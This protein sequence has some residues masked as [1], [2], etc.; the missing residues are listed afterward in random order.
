MKKL[1]IA[2]TFLTPAVFLAFSASP[3]EAEDAQGVQGYVTRSFYADDGC[4]YR[5]IYDVD[6]DGPHLKE[7]IKDW[8]PPAAQ[9]EQPVAT[10]PALPTNPPALD[11]PPATT[12]PPPPATDLPLPPPATWLYKSSVKDENGCD[13][14]RIYEFTRD[15]QGAITH[16][17]V[18]TAK[19]C[20]PKPV[21]APP[22][23]VVVP[24][25]TPSAWERL[26]SWCRGV[27]ECRTEDEEKKEHNDA[28]KQYREEHRTS[29]ASVGK[30]ETTVPQSATSVKDEAK[31]AVQTSSAHSDNNAVRSA[32]SGSVR[33]DAIFHP[34]IASHALTT[35]N[36]G[37]MAPSQNH[38]PTG[39]ARNDFAG[40]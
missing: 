39:M 25:P 33:R 38:A 15:A 32:S 9:P 36:F 27:L 17:I 26:K 13:D 7:T 35:T 10:T 8:C 4:L 18:G 12:N 29:D 14:V 20:P 34:S 31:R 23:P 21:A 2:A 30:T 16:K 37:R 19:N 11:P 1:L 24:M 28:L 40:G 6:S 5:E 22:P 3:A